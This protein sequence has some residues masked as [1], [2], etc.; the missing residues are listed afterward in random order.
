MY[1]Q[2]A[3][4]RCR[5]VLLRN[6]GTVV[7]AGCNL[8]GERNIPAPGAGL[9][10]VHVAAEVAITVVIRSDCIAFARGDTVRHGT[11]LQPEQ[12]AGCVQAAVSEDHVAL[13][14][15]NGT[16]VAFGDNRDNQRNIPRLG[17]GESYA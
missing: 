6:D 17:P 13:L 2:V 5:A 1:I 3:A 9:R 8:H 14:A 4:S 10:C 12:G 11:I 15:S 16:V 7:T